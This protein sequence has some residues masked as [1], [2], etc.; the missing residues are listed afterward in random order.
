MRTMRNIAGLVFVV[1]VLAGS[2]A[3]VEAYEE[4][5]SDSWCETGHMDYYVYC[6]FEDDPYSCNQVGWQ[7]ANWCYGISGGMGYFQYSCIGSDPYGNPP[8][9]GDYSCYWHTYEAC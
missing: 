9:M 8:T 7:A 3:R 5:Y 1:A 4:C 6:G 2:Q